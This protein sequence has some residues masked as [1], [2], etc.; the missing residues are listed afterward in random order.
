MRRFFSRER[1]G[2][3]WL[4]EKEESA[5]PVRGREGSKFGEEGSKEDGSMLFGLVSMEDRTGVVVP[6]PVPGMKE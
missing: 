3:G 5:V 1:L 4:V 2:G 6:E